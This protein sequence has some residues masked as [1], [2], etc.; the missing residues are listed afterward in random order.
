MSE[1]ENNYTSPIRIDE[2]GRYQPHLRTKINLAGLDKYL[3]RVTYIRAD[4]KTE[5]G[6]GW[7]FV[8][9]RLGEH[10]WRQYKCRMVLE[11]RRIWVVGKRFGLSYTITDIAVKERS[12]NS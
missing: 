8:Q 2:S 3:T 9:E 11:A 6:L 7:D 1:I 12:E 10:K 4:G 5:E